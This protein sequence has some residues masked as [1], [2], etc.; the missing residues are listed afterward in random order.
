MFVKL[1]SLYFVSSG[2]V[3]GGSA[4]NCMNFHGQWFTWDDWDCEGIVDYVCECT[5]TLP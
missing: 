4:E 2:W 5:K 1:M 3:D